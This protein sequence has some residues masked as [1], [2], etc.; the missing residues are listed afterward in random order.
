MSALDYTNPGDAEISQQYRLWQQAV[1][2]G[3]ATAAKEHRE[4][5]LALLDR[6]REETGQ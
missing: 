1:T 6:K 5:Y 4:M 2:Y 3:Y